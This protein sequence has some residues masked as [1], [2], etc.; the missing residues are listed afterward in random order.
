MPTYLILERFDR[1]VCLWAAL[2]VVLMWWLSRRSLAGLG[3]IRGKLCMVI[4]AAVVVILVLALAGMNKIRKNEDLN[5]LFLLDTSRS[6][7]AETRHQAEEFVVRATKDMRPNDRVSVLTFDGQ[8]NIEQL[9]CRP[10]PDGGIH[11][12][13]PFPDGQKPDRTNIAQALRM[14]AACALDSTRNR[15]VLLSDGNQNVGDALEEAKTASANKIVVDVLPLRVAH[16]AEV[17]NEQLRAPAYANV[18]EQVSLRLTLKSDQRTSGTILIY[19][20]VGQNEELLRLGEDSGDYGQRV[21]LEKGRNTFIVPLPVN[22]ARAHEWRSVFK[23][24][25]PTADTIAQNNVARAFTNIEGPRTVLFVDAEADQEEDRLLVDA[26][27][28][29]GINVQWENAES[30]DLGTSVLQD[31]AA[32]IL[33]NVGGELLQRRAAAGHGDVRPGPGRRPDHDRRHGQFRRRRMAGVSRRR[34][35]AR[36]V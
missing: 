28:K 23:P 24:D 26:M 18:H 8:T 15:I 34:H 11:I 14:A 5:V 35:H 1:P 20:R 17:V 21:T 25:D 32:I 12:A 3:P 27:V 4:R 22:E 33:A 9:P 16:G 13:P 10:G 36:Q 19:Q 2:V 6:V 29:E 7:S 30:V 31:Y